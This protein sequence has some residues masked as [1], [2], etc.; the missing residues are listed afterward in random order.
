MPK[1]LAG[2]HYW[3]IGASEGIGRTL[4]KC[5]AKEDAKLTVSAR[6]ED[7]LNSLVEDLEGV[8]H[9]ALPLDVT[10]ADSLDA[11]IS[12]VA[13]PDGVIYLAGIY[14]PMGASEA[15]WELARKIIDVNLQGV[16]NVLG[17][18]VPKMV[19]RDHGHIVL[20]GS[21][22]GYVGLPNAIGY[23]VSKAGIMHLAEN[24]HVDL[25]HTNIR[26]QLISPG[27]V[28]TQ[29]TDKNE[30]EMPFKV[31]AEEAAEAI[32]KGLQTS[33]FE[34]HFP[35]KFTY[36]MKLLRLLPYWLYLPLGAKIAEKARQRS[37]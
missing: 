22:A 28:E 13:T 4:A 18:I 12:K 29:L 30:F 8:G 15:D 6:S 17:R 32:V 31:T 19:A 35:K 14:E 2:K 26:T 3:L 27:F 33:S 20:T 1:S 7:R 21:V 10:D 34:I 9:Q 25:A 37:K 24:L 11:A 16:I 36:I 23:G 5:M